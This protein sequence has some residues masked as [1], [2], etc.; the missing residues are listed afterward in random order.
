M[1]LESTSDAANDNEIWSLYL[2]A[3][4]QGLN[5]APTTS[6]L[7]ASSARSLALNTATTLNPVPVPKALA[8]VHRL[9]NPIP[10]WSTAYEPT[11]LSVYAQY[12]AFVFGIAIPEGSGGNFRTVREARR[13]LRDVKEQIAAGSGPYVMT[14]ETDAG[15]SVVPRFDSSPLGWPGFSEWLE[16][17]IVAFTNGAPPAINITVSGSALASQAPQTNT[18]QRPFVR[19]STRSVVRASA[20][21]EPFGLTADLTTLHLTIQ[22]ATQVALAPG[23]WFLGSLLGQ[24]KLN[25]DFEPTSPFAQHP[26]WGPDGI[27]ALV[28]TVLYAGFRPQVTISLDAAMF[29]SLRWVAEEAPLTLGV[30]PFEFDL[31]TEAESRGAVVWDARE[32]TIQASDLSLQGQLLGIT[33]A[34][35]NWPSGPL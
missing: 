33:A 23:A 5:L 13:I 25:S 24:Y 14:I 4:R 9:A 21:A 27:F 11:L 1:D 26:I 10:R 17:S 18:E 6:I 15:F 19:L 28:P 31:G 16:T 3:L 34:A 29:D 7:A 2:K 20:P 12:D 8:E 22:S 32:S 30:G 35:P